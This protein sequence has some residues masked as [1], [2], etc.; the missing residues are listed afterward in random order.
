MNPSKFDLVAKA[1]A[2]RKSRRQVLLGLGSG[3]LAGFSMAGRHADAVM[4]QTEADP[5][6]TPELRPDLDPL[7]PSLDPIPVGLDNYVVDGKT[8]FIDPEVA[9]SLSGTPTVPISIEGETVFI[10]LD[11]VTAA[12]ATPSASPAASPEAE[13]P[14]AACGLDDSQDVES[15]NGNLGVSR[16]FVASNQSA[17]G[18]LRWNNDL[19]NRYV[20]PGT[21]NARRW[22]TG[23]LISDDLFL[24][25]GHCFAQR[26]RGSR[27]PTID[28]TS[29]PIPRTE[30]AT[31]MH[32]DF[33]YQLDATSTEQAWESFPIIELVED[34]L[35]DLD[36]AIV[37]LAGNPGLTYGRARIAATDV[38]VGGTICIIGHPRGEPKRIEA[39]PA[40]Q[41]QNNR[42][43]YNDIDT[44]WGS[45]GSG[46]LLSPDGPIVGVHTTGGC[47][48]A[49]S[50]HNSGERISGLLQ[51][52]QLLRGLGQ[53]GASAA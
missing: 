49:R 36:Y 46:I 42:I 15:Y 48:G 32:V 43:Y 8:I 51:A 1:W 18:N 29:N 31:N 47:T 6:A 20:N 40:S 21:V 10:N 37:R 39:G 11:A 4:G 17:V 25:A 52:S 28:G 26:P 44:D 53:S 34:Q 45:S 14:E 13:F 2:T 38:P 5:A 16:E 24:T 50:G 41:F 9:A 33:R 27:V 23:T 19:I 3:A 12:A 30:I 7:Y 22:C 35:A